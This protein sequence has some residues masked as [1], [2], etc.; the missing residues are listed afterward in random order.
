MFRWL[1]VCLLLAASTFALVSI[2]VG[3]IPF[4]FPSPPGV[5]DPQDGDGKVVPVGDGADQTPAP[6]AAPFPRIDVVPLPTSVGAD[7]FFLVQDARVQAIQRQDV[8]SERDGKLIFLAT[9][10][11]PE[12]QQQI[13]KLK[14]EVRQ[15]KFRGTRLDDAQVFQVLKEQGKLPEWCVTH[16]IGF[17]AVEVGPNESVP[18]GQRFVFRNRPG[19]EYRRARPDD[20]LQPDRCV[21]ARETK[22]FRKLEVG[23][24]VNERQLV[25]LVNPVLA[26]D[27][28]AVKNAKLDA[29]EAD[30]RASEKTRDEYKQRWENML[31]A[32]QRTRS[33]FAQDDIRAAKLQYER[34]LEEEIHKAAEVRQGQRELNAAMTTLSMHRIESTIPGTVKTLYKNSGEAVKNLE[35]V[36]QIQNPDLLRAEGSVEVQV[37]QRLKAMRARTKKDVEVL[38]E[39]SQPEPPAAVLDK[40]HLGE[41]TCVAVSKGPNPVIVSGS[42]DRTVRVWEK[43][44]GAGWTPTKVIPHHEVIRTVACTPASAGRNLLLT[45]TSSG[46]G[47]LFDLEKNYELKPLKAHHAGS[48]NCAA[49][50]PDGKVCATG[51]D[52]RTI[53]LWNTD[54]GDRLYTVT[55]HKGPVTSLQY[56]GAGQLIS[57]GKDG[58]LIVWDAA[59][60]KP[61]VRRSEVP[62]RSG[63]VAQLGVSPDGKYVLFDQGREL[64]ILS[65]ASDQL[66]GTLQNS[67]GA[68]NFAILAQFAPDG[69]TILTDGAAPGRLQLWR[70]PIARADQA[71]DKVVGLPATPVRQFLWSTGTVNCAAFAPD[72]TFAV[73][74]TSDQKVLVWSMPKPEEVQS[75]KAQLRYVEEF[76]ENTQQKV[77]I[78]AWFKNP[79][80]IMPG[81]SAAIV[82]PQ[83]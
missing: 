40:G 1:A 25:G 33:A 7:K 60:G 49:F 16:E 73:T 53:C 29:A 77:A 18:A 70:N 22:A 20:D 45:G 69:R 52:D 4:V 58:S 50:S 83:E 76:Q 55:A 21:V 62:G 43:L 75:I 48:I 14:E 6:S 47:R 67:A 37:A 13:D 27:E 15:G 11:T 31:N 68:G 46:A 3:K 79:G 12:E 36:M 80:W 66:V 10:L 63:D 54:T 42:E 82:I 72:G 35:S 74:G 5:R 19:K 65:L 56:A 39:A 8:P 59:P 23:D 81:G 44:S 30:R 34:Y 57:A 28:M 61:P 26:L 64:R 24:H 38:V 51:G 71:G 41:V 32:V 17:L 78:H 2:A 9:E